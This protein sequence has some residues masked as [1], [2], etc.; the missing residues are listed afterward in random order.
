MSFFSVCRYIDLILA[1]LFWADPSS[2]CPLSA[3][4]SYLCVTDFFN[5][6][7]N[8]SQP[9]MFQC[10]VCRSGEQPLVPT[11]S[12]KSLAG[13]LSR[14]SPE[15]SSSYF[16]RLK[17]CCSSILYSQGTISSSNTN[18]FFSREC[19]M[20]SGRIPDSRITY[21]YLLWPSRSPVIS[22]SQA[23]SR[24][25]R[26]FTGNILPRA[27]WSALRIGQ[28]WFRLDFGGLVRMQLCNVYHSGQL[29]EHSVVTPRVPALS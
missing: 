16:A 4:C 8:N 29:C 21:G 17:T 10:I 24:T 11:C 14:L 9:H 27:V 1:V 15:T 3:S 23:P 26:T 20:I 28:H 5:N 12:A 22:Q 19:S 6:C 13:C 2:A 18:C 7:I 25:E